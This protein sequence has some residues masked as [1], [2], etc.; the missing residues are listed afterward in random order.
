[1]R[2]NKSIKSIAVSLKPFKLEPGEHIYAGDGLYLITG[3]P[4]TG[5][6]QSIKVLPVILIEASGATPYKWKE[7]K[8]CVLYLGDEGVPGFAYD[9][10][11]CT[12]ARSWHGAK[13]ASK[14]YSVWLKRHRLEN[15]FFDF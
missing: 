12:L 9:N 8:A 14:A 15:P 10:R 3:V 6:W 11:P 4:Y 2:T 1:M 5:C 13:E 7:G